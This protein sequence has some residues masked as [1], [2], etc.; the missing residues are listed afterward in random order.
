MYEGHLKSSWTH[1]ITLSQN[2][3]EVQWRFLFWSTSLDK[4][5]T[6]FNTPPTS[7]KCAADHWSLWNFLPQSS[8]FMVGISP[9]IARGEIWT[10]S[11]A[12]LEKV[13]GGTPLEHLPYSPDLTPCDLWA[14]PTMKRELWGKKFWSDQQSA[15]CSQEVGREL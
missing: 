10:E 13:D 5:C 15:A 12:G 2:F 1:L 9:E 6:S 4:W 14:S 11:C 8:L 3:V 7:W